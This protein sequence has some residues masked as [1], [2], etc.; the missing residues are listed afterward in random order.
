MRYIYVA[1]LL[2]C[3]CG[4]SHMPPHYKCNGDAVLSSHSCPKGGHGPCFLCDKQYIK[5]AP[6]NIIYGRHNILNK[7]AVK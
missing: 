3:S 5:Q 4:C 1:I 7:R 6:E 2:Y